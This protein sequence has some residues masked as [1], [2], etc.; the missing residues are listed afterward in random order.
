MN[1]KRRFCTCVRLN[2]ELGIYTLVDQERAMRRSWES[3][4]VADSRSARKDC[5]LCKGSGARPPEEGGAAQ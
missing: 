5:P 4:L 3:G 1:D 2:R